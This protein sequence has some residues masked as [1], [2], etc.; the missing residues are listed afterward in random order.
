MLD[1]ASF[2]AEQF[3]DNGPWVD[4]QT[5]LDNVIEPAGTGYVFGPRQD[6]LTDIEFDNEVM[7]L[8]IRDRTG[9]IMGGNVANSAGNL[10]SY[11]AQG[12][13]LCASDDDSDGVYQVANGVSTCG[14][15]TS[16]ATGSP[17]SEFF[18]GDGRLDGG[19]AFHSE[20]SNGGL[21]F[22]PTRDSIVFSACLL[23]TSPSPRDRTRSRMPS[24][25]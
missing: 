7:W 18:V 23:Y 22:H 21:Q 5:L 4:G 19:D 6:W 16:G 3:G 25:A 14:D 8:G 9:D 17:S 1:N 24:S 13:I 11:S 15:R 12:T 10:V 2:G 20:V